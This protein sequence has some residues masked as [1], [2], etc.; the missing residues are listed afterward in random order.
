M[1]TTKTLTIKQEKNLRR[2][3]E[4]ILNPQ[5]TNNQTLTSGHKINSVNNAF[6]EMNLTKKLAR[7]ILG[8]SNKTSDKEVIARHIIQSFDPNDDLTPEEVHEIGRQTALEFLGEDYEFVIATH[9]DTDHLH[10]HIIFNTTSSV[11]LK[12]FRWQK[13]TTSH[14]RNTS[15]KIA[16]YHGATIL[17]TSKRNSYTKYQEYRRK[18]AF[19]TELKERLNFL[20]KHSTSW[21]DFLLKASA[22]NIEIDTNH[23]SKEY[24]Q[25]INYKLLDMP[26]KRPA[27][28]YTINKKHRIYN[29]EN[30]V[31]RTSQN[32]PKAVFQ[33]GEIITKYSEHKAQKEELPDMTFIIEP[34][35]IEKDTMTGIYV[36]IEYGRYEKGVVKI[37]DYKL[38][39][40]EDGRYEAHFNYKDAFYFWSDE[41]IQKNKFVKGASLAKYLSGESGLMPKRKNSAIQNVREMV[42]ALN[43]ISNRNVTSQLA[44]NVLGQDFHDNFEAVQEA[45]AT[46]KEK[47]TQLNDQLKYHPQDAILLEKVKALREEKNE[48]EK[49]VK[50]FEK[51]LQTYDAA[52]GILKDKGMI[53][54]IDFEK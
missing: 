31:E 19:R 13:A 24:G 6:F 43:I 20:L 1:P 39:L 38:D 8:K 27:R 48:L 28:D 53:E 35:Q 16:D 18:H 33:V 52:L 54:K 2:A 37:P 32:N 30:I 25:V 9:T 49:E 3:I 15:D 22:L 17:A 51:Q 21:D 44:P 7:N 26:Q 36:E 5:K 41:S 4:Y 50:I 47:M 11:D 45:R 12:K 23:Q 34:W 10:N 14:L 29:M 46:L 42:T 40:R